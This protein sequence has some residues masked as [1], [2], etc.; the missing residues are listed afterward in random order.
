ME[1]WT[2]DIPIC[3]SAGIGTVN[4]E[5]YRKDGRRVEMHP[6]RC[7][8][9]HFRQDDFQLC[10]Y[11]LFDGF[12]G[13][14]VS[15]FAMKRLPAELLLGQLS[16]NSSD[17]AVRDVLR[18]AFVNVDR[19]YIESTMEAIKARIVLREDHREASEDRDRKLRE[20][21]L[22]ARIGCSATAAV[23][24]N[25]KLFVANVGDTRAVLCSQLPSGELR[26]TKL[27]VDHV[28][29]NEDEDLRLSQLGLSAEQADRA[30]NIP[31]YT[32]CLG[33]HD[34]KGGY[35]DVDALRSA[36][37][38]PVLAEPEISCVA[39]D[40]SFQFVVI[41]SRSVADCLSQVC[42]FSDGWGGDISHELCR[43]AL[44]Q[45]S[46]NTTVTGVAQSVVDKIVRLH[47]EQFEM[48]STTTTTP[49]RG[50]DCTERE[51]MCLLVRN[52]NA[53]LAS[54]RRKRSGIA[55]VAPTD[56]TNTSNASGGVM[57]MMHR[58]PEDTITS[59][60]T[61]TEGSESTQGAQA[62]QNERKLP[63]LPNGRIQPYVDF[64]HFNREWA[65]AQA[66]AGGGAAVNGTN[67]H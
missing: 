18:Q 53:K 60:S 41:Y 38:E 36:R 29:G 5:I 47:R 56:T 59:K 39:I 28:L 20:L 52:F 51:D 50:V 37:D 43:I 14:Q 4:N 13:S 67:K 40:P 35:T 15:D 9:F 16:H 2:D 42:S 58:Q 23:I 57:S 6:M 64:S 1:A 33:Y 10:T 27:S 7:R 3:R 55:A 24:V 54:H 34:A 49:A 66:A 44:E 19:E 22:Q 65:K 30:L 25:K 17:D 12:C 26:V 61:T 48:E 21:D 31:G 11:G 62:A 32:R 8:Y 46:E 63:L 45:F